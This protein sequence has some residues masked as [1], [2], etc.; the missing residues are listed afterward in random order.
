MKMLW[1]ASGMFT[2]KFTIVL[3]TFLTWSCASPP[4]KIGIQPFTD[5]SETLMD[6]VQSSIQSYYGADVVI[7]PSVEHREK[8]FVQIKSP[9][10]RADSIIRDLKRSKPE[11]LE[12]VI[13]LTTKDISTTKYEG[14][15]IKKPASKYEDW[16]IFGLGYR[17]GGS[18][19]VST[20][21]IQHHDRR[22]YLSRIRKICL[23]EIGHNLGLKHCE[24][25]CFMKDAAES[26]KTIDA[27]PMEL[28]E[29][30]RNKIGL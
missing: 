29:R 1:F 20:F 24:N 6:S 7:L 5:F 2:T 13:G 4:E 25:E 26:I 3:S 12:L 22:I 8:N 27:V 23:H 17:P 16:G 11:D 19:V 18:C 10:F 21:R 9:R 28:C 30:C 15:S 14:G